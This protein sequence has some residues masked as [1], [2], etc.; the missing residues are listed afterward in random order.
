MIWLGIVIIIIIITLI[1]IVVVVIF[2]GILFFI[3]LLFFPF[4][5]QWRW[6][7]CLCWCVVWVSSVLKPLW[8]SKR[9][10]CFEYKCKWL[11]LSKPPPHFGH[12]Y[13]TSPTQLIKKSLWQRWKAALAALHLSP[14]RHYWKQTLDVCF[15][16]EN[17]FACPHVAMLDAWHRPRLSEGGGRCLVAGSSVAAQRHGGKNPITFTVDVYVNVTSVF[18]NTFMWLKKNST[19]F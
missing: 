1:I 15:M 14:P 8:Q 19:F 7:I 2:V 18:F 9:R 16:K 17:I 3:S 4:T 10:I 5:H 12:L 13:S 6:I 11:L